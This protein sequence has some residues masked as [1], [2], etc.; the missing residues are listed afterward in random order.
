MVVVVVAGAA[1]AALAA[2][3]AAVVVL[4]VV[5]SRRLEVLGYPSMYRLPSLCCL[6]VCRQE[7]RRLAPGAAAPGLVVVVGV[8][9]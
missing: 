9:T 3:P 6:A 7:V 1:P 8:C 5:A 4:A 2:A